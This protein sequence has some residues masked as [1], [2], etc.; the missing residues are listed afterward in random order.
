MANPPRGL[1]LL[2]PPI[3]KLSIL[4]VCG[5]SG[6]WFG[7]LPYFFEVGNHGGPQVQQLLMTCAG[8]KRWQTVATLAVLAVFLGRDDARAQIKETGDLSI[9]LVDP[10]VLR[11]C[12]DPH[13]LPFPTKRAKDSRTSLPNCSPRS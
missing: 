11:V 3:D 2:Q 12:A 10:K 1:F 5:F 9:E 8:Q 4:L 13:N 7:G 6:T